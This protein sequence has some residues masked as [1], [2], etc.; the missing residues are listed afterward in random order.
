MRRDSWAK[1]FS[2]V[3]MHGQQNLAEIVRTRDA[4]IGFKEQNIDNMKS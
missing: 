3:N 2:F 4:N 1:I